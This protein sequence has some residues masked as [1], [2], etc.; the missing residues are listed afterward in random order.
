LKCLPVSSLF[1]NLDHLAI[2]IQLDRDPV[3]AVVRVIDFD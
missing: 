2:F 3:V 1:S